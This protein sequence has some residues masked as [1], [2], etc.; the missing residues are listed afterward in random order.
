MNNKT[1]IQ[2]AIDKIDEYIGDYEPHTEKW[3]LLRAVKSS[4][5]A[6]LPAERECIEKAWNDGSYTGNIM[7]ASDYFNETFKSE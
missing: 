2:M 3:G 7:G 5:E 1:P 6:I 4:M